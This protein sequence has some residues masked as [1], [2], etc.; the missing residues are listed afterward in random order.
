MTSRNSFSVLFVTVAYKLHQLIT[1]DFFSWNQDTLR[2]HRLLSSFFNGFRAFIEAVE[3][4]RGVADEVVVVWFL[5]GTAWCCVSVSSCCAVE[6]DMKQPI[7]KRTWKRRKISRTTKI[8]IKWWMHTSLVKYEHGIHCNLVSSSSKLGSFQFIS[9]LAATIIRLELVSI[10]CFFLFPFL[11][12]FLGLN[13][14]DNMNLLVHA[15]YPQRLKIIS[16][17]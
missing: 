4:G 13:M 15:K 9:L 16:S 1:Y 12:Q 8:K 11:Y 7:T 2:D 10:T 14:M 5:E 17:F 6:F 3:E